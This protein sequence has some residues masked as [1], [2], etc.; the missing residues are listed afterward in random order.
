MPDKLPDSREGRMVKS[1]LILIA[2]ATRRQ[3][4][5]Y[6]DLGHHLG[7]APVATPHLNDVANFCLQ[8]GHPDLT[9]LVVN[10][11][12][13]LTGSNPDPKTDLRRREEVYRHEWLDYAP[14]SPAD[15]ISLQGSSSI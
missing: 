8:K 2:A 6:G 1:Y 15:W 10:S 7:V 13:G 12:T 14:P 9:F 3:T 5:T 4:I 11:E